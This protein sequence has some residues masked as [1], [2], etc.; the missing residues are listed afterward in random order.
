MMV[1]G[2]RLPKCL[3]SALK[4]AVAVGFHRR[5]VLQVLGREAAAEVDHRQV[6]AALAALLEHGR[7]RGERPVPGMLVALLRA[8]MERHA[9][10]LEAELDGRAPARPTAMAGSQPNLRDSGHSAPT[11]S[12]RMRQNTLRAGRGAG[13]LLDLGLAVDRVE[14]D[15]ER[16][17]ARD[18]A[19]LLDR[20][21]VG[22][23]VGRGAGR[24]HHLD[25]GDRGGVEAGAELG[26]QRQ[27]L[28]RRVGLDGVEHAGVGQ[29][30]G[31]G[32]VVVAHDVE[33]DDE[34]RAFV[35]AA[36]RRSAGIRGCAQSLAHLPRLRGG[37]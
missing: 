26:Q 28:R 2:M 9:I 13:D 25:L 14:A 34:D 35:V 8:D 22:D 10:R 19:L 7:R 32:G 24:E 16:V 15:A 31:E 21:A 27:H 1:S 23:A 29:G 20:V 33:V 37:M 17:G 11:Q 3:R 18:V 30:L 12:D 6:H 36:S 5:H 4:I